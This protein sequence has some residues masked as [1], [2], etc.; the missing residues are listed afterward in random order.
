MI[1]MMKGYIAGLRL[2]VKILE[3]DKED[4][5][6]KHSEAIHVLNTY[7]S[8]IAKVPQSAVT[9]F[10][11]DDF[12]GEQDNNGRGQEKAPDQTARHDRL[13]T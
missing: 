10:T 1:N 7:M 4:R 8:N 5:D 11:E 12:P 13:G 3:L 9:Y 2:S 6:G